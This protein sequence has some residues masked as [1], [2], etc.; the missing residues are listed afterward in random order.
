MERLLTPTVS[1]TPAGIG[2]DGRS[3]IPTKAN[4]RLRQLHRRTSG[5]R[6]NETAKKIPPSDHPA[7]WRSS[8]TPPKPQTLPYP[9]AYPPGRCVPGQGGR[10]DGHMPPGGQGGYST[11]PLREGVR[12]INGGTCPQGLSPL[13]GWIRSEAV[14]VGI[15]PGICQLMLPTPLPVGS[16]SGRIRDP[17]P[18]RIMS[19]VGVLR[20]A[21]SFS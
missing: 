8:H 7:S 20:E 1:R 9:G 15:P 3:H 10:A 4:R 13:Y 16:R 17:L 5:F 12:T 11:F 2:P 14:W 18:G 21:L 6:S 19:H